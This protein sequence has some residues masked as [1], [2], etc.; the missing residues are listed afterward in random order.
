MHVA[1]LHLCTCTNHLCASCS[2]CNVQS[3][4]QFQMK[5]YR[6]HLRKYF[7]GCKVRCPD[8]GRKSFNLY[9][10]SLGEVA[11]TEDIGWCDHSG[12]N[13]Q[14]DH[15]PARYFQEHPEK[16]PKGYEDNRT[17]IQ[18]LLEKSVQ[19]DPCRR[20]NVTLFVEIRLTPKKS[21]RR[22]SI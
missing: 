5:D 19:I 12:C 4:F 15:S 2:T 8:C 10:D 17:T 11:F 18:S 22:G 16:R 14:H 20:K 13:S 3:S 21:W 1:L 9:V 7:P 6:F